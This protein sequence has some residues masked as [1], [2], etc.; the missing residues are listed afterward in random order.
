MRQWHVDPRLL[1][2][3]HLL[4]E[5]VEHHMM[6]GAIRHG[7]SIAG[8][9][10]KGLIDVRTI[11]ERHDAIATEMEAR[12][13]KHQSPLRPYTLDGL[14][15]ASVNPL[16]SILELERRCKACARRIEQSLAKSFTNHTSV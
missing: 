16:V 15:V 3:K 9:V 11:R 12:G 8:W 7:L 1:C 4:G 13:I 14:H 2:Q 6:V 5:H 10:G